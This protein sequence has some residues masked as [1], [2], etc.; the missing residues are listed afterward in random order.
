M[1]YQIETNPKFNG[2]AIHSFMLSEE[3]VYFGTSKHLDKKIYDEI[4][5]A[6]Y[7]LEEAGVLKGIRAK[8]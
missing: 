1:K 4:V 7:E 6:F 2:L 3:D 8:Y 5:K